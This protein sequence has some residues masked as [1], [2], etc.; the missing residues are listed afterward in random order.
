MLVKLKT[1]MLFCQKRFYTRGTLTW[2]A[3]ILELRK[4]LIIELHIEVKEGLKGV[5][6]NTQKAAINVSLL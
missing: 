6:C 3:E 2:L 4:R 1:F 5:H